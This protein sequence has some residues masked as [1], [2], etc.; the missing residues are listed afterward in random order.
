MAMLAS[1]VFAAHALVALVAAVL[2]IAARRAATAVRAL[3][4]C[5][6]A[7]TCAYVQVMAPAVAAAQLVLLGGA[8]IVVLRLV[9]VDAP[10]RGGHRG[11]R[12]RAAMPLV[13][14]GALALVL[15]GTWARQYVWTGRELPPGTRFGQW[16]Q[17]GQ[18]WSELYAPTLGLALLALSV[19]AIAGLAGRE[20]RL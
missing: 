20:L 19:A 4:V 11:A 12:W 15:V 18:V 17:L 13:P 7:V 9:V 2:V 16:A 5:M 3:Q 14:V 8:A 6:V 10:E 1:I